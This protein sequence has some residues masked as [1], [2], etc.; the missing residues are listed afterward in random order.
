MTKRKR[1]RIR[2]A[3]EFSPFSD[4]DGDKVP[5][6]LDC[7]PT[8]SNMD[9]FFGDI[10]GAIKTRVKTEVGELKER[11]IETIA[12]GEAKERHKEL[13][14]AEQEA[15]LEEAREQAEERGRE[16]A[17]AK[18][19]RRKPLLGG[20]I[21]GTDKEI[22]ALSEKVGLSLKKV[23]RHG[24]GILK[25]TTIS[26]AKTRMPDAKL[27]D[28]SLGGITGRDVLKG[29]FRT[30]KPHK[31][32]TKLKVGTKIPDASMPDVKW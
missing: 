4:I 12:G 11:T 26:R 23:G 10:G 1:D 30:I 9:G 22:P 15:Y 3:L 14:E 24:K 21:G 2:K 7:R 20:L 25:E 5:N 19:V 16:K 13:H 31:G 28:T 8:D 27:P 17:R 29:T 32:G 6:I 18:F